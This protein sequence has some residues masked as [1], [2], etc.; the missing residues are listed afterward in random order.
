MKRN[1]TKFVKERKPK[2]ASELTKR[3]MAIEENFAD[4]EVHRGNT[5][6]I[7]TPPP[8]LGLWWKSETAQMTEKNNFFS[9][10]NSFHFQESIKPQRHVFELQKWNLRLALSQIIC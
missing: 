5:T 7:S 6:Y 2:N 8:D 9:L 4:I 1:V 10:W 3:M